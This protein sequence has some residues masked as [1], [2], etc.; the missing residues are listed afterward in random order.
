MAGVGVLVYDGDCG[1]CTRSAQWAMRRAH[2]MQVVPWQQADL[3]SLG[4]TADQCGSAVQFVRDGTV[5]SGGAA[6]AEA[7]REC[8][9]PYRAAGRL[10]GARALR[11]LVERGYALVARNRHRL[12]G[13][14]AA[15][16][17]D[18]SSAVAVMPPAIAAT[19]DEASLDR[20]EGPFV[21]TLG[22]GSGPAIAPADR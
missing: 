18:A 15:C 2:G 17:L 1:F 14:T 16:A 4:L 22:Q 19:A 21:G 9:L 8:G 20:D 13:S 10:L 6:V 12:P 5:R 3:V 7:L 11:P